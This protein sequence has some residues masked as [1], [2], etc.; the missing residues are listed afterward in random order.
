MSSTSTSRAVVDVERVGP[1]AA[2]AALGVVQGAFAA[3]PPLDPPAEALAETASSLAHRLER[4]GGLLA[5]VDGE[6]AGALVLDP[7][8]PTTWTAPLR[9]AARRAGPRR[10]GPPGARRRRGRPAGRRARAGRR[11][12][13]GAAGHGRLLAAPRLLRGRPHLPAG[14]A[15]P[16]AAHAAV[17]LV[18]TAEAM[19]ALGRAVAT[20]ARGRRPVGP[21]RRSRRR[22]DHLHPGPGRRARRPRPG[23]LPD[24]RHRAGPPAARLRPGPG[25]RRRLP[26]RRAPPSSTTSTSTP[27][28]RTPSPS[29]SGARAWPRAWPSRGSRCAWSARTTVD[30]RR[31]RPAPRRGHA[32]GPALARHLL[33]GCRGDPGLAHDRPRHRHP[34]RRA[35]PRPPPQPGR[36][37]PPAL[38]GPPA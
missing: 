22:Q 16:A 25:A 34:P 17:R 3:R 12:P 27:R 29:S 31:A 24:V 38:P 32:R 10:R 8:G 4:G 36:A 15:A 7:A 1:E 33:A 2:A 37:R 11:R 13:R 5:R 35:A 14:R 9:R 26:A 18:E 6:P 28:W 30:R 23:H 20:P 19:R 21:R